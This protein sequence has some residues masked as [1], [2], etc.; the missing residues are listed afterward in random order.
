MAITFLVAGQSNAAGRLTNRQTWSHASLTA[1]MWRLVDSSWQTLADP[2]WVSGLSGDGSVWP[3]LATHVMAARGEAVDFLCTAVGATSLV[4]GDW[5][6][7][8]GDQYADCVA[9]VLASGVTSIDALL[10]DQGEGE[11]ATAAGVDQAEYY[12]AL[13]AMHDQL[14]IDTGLAFPMIVA[15]TGTVPY[16]LGSTDADIDEVRAAQWQAVESEA[17]IF[18]GPVGYDRAGIHWETDAEALVLAARWW[19]AIEAALYG[20]DNR[21][22]YVQSVRSNAARDEVTLTLSKPLAALAPLGGISVSDGGVN[23]DIVGIGAADDIVTILLDGR[24]AGRGLVTYASGN[25]QAGETVPSGESIALPGGGTT[26][27]PLEPFVGLVVVP[28]TPTGVYRV[29]SRIP[30]LAS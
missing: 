28:E 9:T 22:P 5:D 30:V 12:A 26:Q 1:R 11:C 8:T 4:D 24:L 18:P 15:Q 3:L 29:P 23:V 17:D 20:G 14:Q 10:W 21:G 7:Q 27:L 13:L 16:A 25:A 6:P 19:L 2:T